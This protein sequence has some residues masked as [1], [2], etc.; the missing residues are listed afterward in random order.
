[1]TDRRLADPRYAVGWTIVL[2]VGLG[3][4]AVHA[5]HVLGEPS[6]SAGQL[7]LGVVFPTFFSLILVGAGIDLHRRH[8]EPEEMLR[9]G[10]WAGMGFLLFVWIG[11]G[12]MLYYLVQDVPVYDPVL[13]AVYDPV[14]VAVT[15]GSAGALAGT[16]IG[17]YD[18]R[19]GRATD[20]FRTQ[21]DRAEQLTERL[22]ILTRVFRHDIRTELTVIKGHTRLAGSKGGAAVEP[23]LDTITERTETIEELSERVR[24]VQKTVDEATKQKEQDLCPILH[25]LAAELED[26]YPDASIA[27][28][29]PERAVVTAS[30]KLGAAVE[31]ILANAIEHGDPEGIEAT[32][33]RGPATVELVVRDSGPGIPADEV[34]PI[35]AAVET[36]LR[37]SSGMGLWTVKWIVEAAGG[38][39]GIER[40]DA[41]TRVTMEFPRAG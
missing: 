19:S 11:A 39:F 13:V 10:A 9:I 32:V 28:E 15:L 35:E 16:L 17:R 30:V 26:R 2:G 34:E 27:I 24:T 1:M 8:Y 29:G 23:H 5:W 40:I 31:E 4:L 25:E 22:N 12:A 6:K 33:N 20:R 21:R 37:H 36:P 14:V 41:G 38:T 18:I 7:L 3:S